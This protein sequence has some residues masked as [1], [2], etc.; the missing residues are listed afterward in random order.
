MKFFLFVCFVFLIRKGMG[1]GG[2][3]LRTGAAK[4]NGGGDRQQTGREA[5]RKERGAGG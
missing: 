4:E 2:Q 5:E 1:K 3:L